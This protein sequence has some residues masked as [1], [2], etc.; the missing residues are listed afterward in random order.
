MIQ[1]GIEPITF[2]LVAHCL[3]QLRHRVPRVI[4]SNIYKNIREFSDKIG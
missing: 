2:R 1:L 3:N 4:I